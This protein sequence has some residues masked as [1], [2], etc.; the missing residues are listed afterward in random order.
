MH[1]K[2]LLQERGR[3]ENQTP[4]IRGMTYNLGE[5]ILRATAIAQMTG[6]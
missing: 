5:A 6:I 3:D 1:V 4:T 2:D